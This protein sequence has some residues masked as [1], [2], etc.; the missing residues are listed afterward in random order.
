[1]SKQE[2][3]L[4]LVPVLDRFQ[5]SVSE[6]TGAPAAEAAGGLSEMPE[7]RG[8]GLRDAARQ[9]GRLRRALLPWG[10]HVRRLQHT[11]LTAP[12]AQAP[13]GQ[14]PFSRSEQLPCSLSGTEICSVTKLDI[15]E[16]L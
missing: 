10:H 3:K 13:P 2:R 7:L 1:M 15:T 14:R 12:S 16:H 8:V 11:R 4:E 6:G 5:T 9:S